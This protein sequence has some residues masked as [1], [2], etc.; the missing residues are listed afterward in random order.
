MFPLNLLIFLL[1]AN[2]TF[3]ILFTLYFDVITIRNR[4]RSSD[5]PRPPAWDN[6]LV[7]LLI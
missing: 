3:Y 2:L 7:T 1:S 6:E 4:D 5:S